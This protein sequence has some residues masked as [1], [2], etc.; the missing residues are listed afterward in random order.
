M[1]RTMTLPKIGVNMTEAIVD[2]WYVKEG[3][4]IAE[5]DA[6]LLAETDKATQDIYATDS[7][8]VGKLLAKEGDKVQIGEPILLLL[9]EGEVFSEETV[10]IKQDAAAPAVKAEKVPDKADAAMKP[11]PAAGVRERKRIS[12]LARKLAKELG[13]DIDKLTP[14]EPG[15]RIVKA[16][17]LA[18][19]EAQ[20]KPSY[21]EQAAPVSGEVLEVVPMRGIRKVIAER[22][23]A[24]NLERP[25]AALTISVDAAGMMALREAFGQDGRRVGYNEIIAKACARALTR[26]RMLNARLGG[27]GI[28]VLRDVNIGIAVD[29]DR[30]LVVPVIRNADG[31]TLSQM[32]DELASL[33]Q[34]VKENRAKPED[35]SGGTFTITN[36]GMLGIEEFTA[37]INPPEC[38]IL[39]VG[40]LR[41]VFVPDED[42]NPVV[43]SEMKMTLSFDH[44]IVDGAPA[45][46]F[47]QD[48]KRYLE[49]PVI[50]L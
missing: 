39:A 26:H 24:S 40:A 17:V 44:R 33:V 47:L 18:Y 50:M 15:K 30:G 36:L 2:S 12:P 9:D 31:K 3:D 6:I 10:I 21:A 35:L 1:A 41:R 25:S 43:R 34:A 46:R 20:K 13:I 42:G 5:G 8:V 14:A 38:A 28:E 37:V 11:L 45:A 19:A 32:A 4:R 23:S 22:M 49:N 16:D 29:T 48:V 7:G 27:D